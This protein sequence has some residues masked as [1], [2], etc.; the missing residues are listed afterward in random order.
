M[1][2]GPNL[3][4]NSSPL[5]KGLSQGG[6]FVVK[7]EPYLPAKPLGEGSWFSLYPIYLPKIYVKK[8]SLYICS[9]Y[10]Q[11]ICSIYYYGRGDG[12]HFAQY[13]CQKYIPNML[14][15]K[16]LMAKRGSIFAQYFHDICPILMYNIFASYILTILQ[17]RQ[18]SYVTYIQSMKSII[19]V[20]F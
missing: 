10:S 17:G 2:L 18:Q 1:D 9:I 14:P 12:F 3:E 5:S 15:N 8:I 7:L 20:R 19:F 4:N 16:F 6:G 13:S 11:Y